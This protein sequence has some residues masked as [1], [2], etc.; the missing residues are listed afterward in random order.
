M[1]TRHTLEQDTR[2]R[3]AIRT[4]QLVNRLQS[5]AL[6]ENDPQ[7]GKPVN[8][9]PTRVKAAIALLKKTLPDLNATTLSGEDGAPLFQ[10]LQVSFVKSEKK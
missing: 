10:G 4:S 5:F 3:S 1:A 6:G 2:T 7:T 8:M 9:D